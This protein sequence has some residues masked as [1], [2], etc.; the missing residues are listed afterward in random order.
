MVYDCVRFVPL[1]CLGP[2]WRIVG[3]LGGV[4]HKVVLCAEV[5][6]GVWLVAHAL[7][8]RSPYG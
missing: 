4:E 5:G 6:I 2:V 3:E 8:T 7:C 1:A